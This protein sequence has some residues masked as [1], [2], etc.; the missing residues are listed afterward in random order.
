MKI[1]GLALYAIDG[2]LAS[3]LVTFTDEHP[4]TQFGVP[5]V[6]VRGKKVVGGHEALAQAVVGTACPGGGVAVGLYV[7]PG[8]TDLE[9]TFLWVAGFRPRK[10]RAH[11]ARAAKGRWDLAAYRHYRQLTSAAGRSARAGEGRGPHSLPASFCLSPC[12]SRH[13][14]SGAT[15]LTR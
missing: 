4:D 10:V 9:I 2:R 12:S 1:E 5:L 3:M 14:R 8:V 11:E 15:G 13:S 6:L 7:G